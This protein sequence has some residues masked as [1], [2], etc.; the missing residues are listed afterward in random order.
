MPK[1]VMFF[2]LSN[3]NFVPRRGLLSVRPDTAQ[4]PLTALGLICADLIVTS[5]QTGLFAYKSFL[6]Y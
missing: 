6:Q 4:A 5:K 3:V 2:L 1:I